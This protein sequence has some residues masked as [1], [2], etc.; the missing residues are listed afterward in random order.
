[1]KRQLEKRLSDKLLAFAGSIAQ[2]LSWWM[3]H[4]QLKVVSSSVCHTAKAENKYF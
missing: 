2:D 1:M 4:T 3:Q